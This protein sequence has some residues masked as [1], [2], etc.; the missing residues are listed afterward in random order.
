MSGPAA[1]SAP[2]APEPAG[3][4]L[5]DERIRAHPW[6]HYQW[7]RENAPVF[8]AA[9]PAPIFVVSRYDL[10]REILSVPA[11]YSSARDR[12][13]G[14]TGRRDRRPR[15]RGPARRSAR[16]L[17]PRRLT[18]VRPDG[19]VAWRGDSRLADVGAL[20]DRVRGATCANESEGSA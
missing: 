10:T 20:L 16:R 7:L 3:F 13:A 11:T 18:L 12:I 15:H 4:D 14:G 5:L 17:Y 6:P 2:P 1:R 19:H 8:R 9:G